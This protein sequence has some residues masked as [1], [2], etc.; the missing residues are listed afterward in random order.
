[1]LVMECVIVVLPLLADRYQ[2]QVHDASIGETPKG[3]E[4]L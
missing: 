2:P 3:D 4:W 1:M